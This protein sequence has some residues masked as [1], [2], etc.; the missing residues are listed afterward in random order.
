MNGLRILSIDWDYFF[1][2][3]FPYDWGHK[4][5]VFFLEAIWP[6]RLNNHN[7]ITGEEAF[8]AYKPSIPKDFWKRTVKGAALLYVAESHASITALPFNHAIVTNLDAH[9]D[10][11]YGHST[12]LECGN[13]AHQAGSRIKEFH[14]VYPS[15]RKIGSEGPS[16]RQ[17]DSIITGLPEQADYD[18]VFVCRSGCWT[19]P[20]YDTRFQA[21]LK[22]S[23]METHFMD[24]YA[25]KNRSPNMKAA[26]VLKVQMDEQFRQLQTGR[27]V[28]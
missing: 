19:P 23:G 6:V 10:C 22:Q 16:Q 1:P 7:I 28:A 20:W 3:S 2:D 24:Q 8:K 12:S 5:V 25:G 26:K 14:Q 11:G 17:P 18:L 27:K 15:W 13:W 21:F 4:E 9:H